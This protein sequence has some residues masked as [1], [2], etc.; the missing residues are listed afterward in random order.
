MS[1]WFQAAVRVLR[2]EEPKIYERVKTDSL[3]LATLGPQELEE[4]GRFLDVL[5]VRLVS[6]TGQEYFVR[7]TRRGTIEFDGTTP[8]SYPPDYHTVLAM[9]KDA[10]G[11]IVMPTQEDV[12][13]GSCTYLRSKI[14][15]QPQL[16]MTEIARAV[17]GYKNA[18]YKD[19]RPSPQKPLKHVDKPNA[20]FSDVPEDI[21]KKYSQRLNLTVE[22]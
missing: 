7:H 10:V 1:N 5:V 15:R 6:L 3:D 22:K 17:A 12:Q 19:A 8:V 14:G 16:S 9:V 2:R 18:E 4:V 11:G 21:Y 20:V 13:L